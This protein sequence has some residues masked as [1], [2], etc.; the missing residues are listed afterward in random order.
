MFALPQ[1]LVLGDKIIEKTSFD[2]NLNMPVS[3]Q[4]TSGLVRVDGLVQGHIDGTVIG[5]M[6]ATVM[7]NVNIIMRSGAEPETLEPDQMFGFKQQIEEK[8]EENKEGGKRNEKAN[9]Q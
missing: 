3:P 6:H 7:G 9:M 1:I 8:A 5:V 2:V 4:A